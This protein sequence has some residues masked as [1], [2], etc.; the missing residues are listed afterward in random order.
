MQSAL[1]KES[2]RTVQ[3]TLSTTVM[4]TNQSMLSKANVTVRSDIRTK[5][6]T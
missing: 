2:V 4:K 3:W 6:S 5:H 1:C